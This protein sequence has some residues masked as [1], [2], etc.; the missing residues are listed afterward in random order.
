MERGSCQS[1]GAVVKVGETAVGGFG[2]CSC[3]SD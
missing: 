1:P 2:E 3:R